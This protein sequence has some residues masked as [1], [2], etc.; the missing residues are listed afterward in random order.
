MDLV[1][2]TPDFD[3][4]PPDEEGRGW[5]YP[6]DVLRH[7][8]DSRMIHITNTPY[9]MPYRERLNNVNEAKRITES[10][11]YSDIF[12]TLSGTN[13]QLYIT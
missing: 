7:D 6:T 2:L 9:A 13:S 4:S 12:A 5:A 11:G 3:F 10:F 8:G 1:E